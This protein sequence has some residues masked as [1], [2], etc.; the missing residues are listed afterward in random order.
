M[1]TQ[2]FI[3]VIT[4]LLLV[5][6]SLQAG[7][8]PGR[9]E[10]LDSQPPGKQ[11]IVTL[12]TGDRMEWD[13]KSSGPDDLTVTDPGGT[14]RRVA[15][16]EVQKILS[17]E[18]TFLGDSLLNGTLIGAAVC[19]TL[20]LIPLIFSSG[21]ADVG[22]GGAWIG[23]CAGMGAGIDALHKGTEVLYQAP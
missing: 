10:K 15:K 6:T 18:K 1:K 11:I 8:I 3:S 20:F 23:F 22:A 12:K 7:V 2:S 4:L 14:E 5:T 19:G 9:W 16:S 13:F 17:A 21:D